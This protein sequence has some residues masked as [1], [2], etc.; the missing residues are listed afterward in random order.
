MAEALL[1]IMARPD[2]AAH[3]HERTFA[4]NVLLDLITR[5]EDAAA[6]RKVARRLRMMERPSLPL[7]RAILA[8]AERSERERILLDARLPASLLVEL[9][10]SEGAQGL[11][12]LARRR[13][14]PPLVSEMLLAWQEPELALELLRN[15][16]IRLEEE[17]YRLLARM[18]PRASALHGPII[19]REDLPPHAAFALFWHVGALQRRFIISRFVGDSGLLRRLLAMARPPRAPMPAEERA[20]QLETTLALMAEGALEEA[21]HN[22]A[23]L[24]GLARATCARIAADGGGEP[25]V[26]TL[27][28]LGL[29]RCRVPEAIMQLKAS[30][31][32]PLARGCSL[33]ELQALFDSLSGEKA[34]VPLLYWHWEETA[35]KAAQ[36]SQ[37]DLPESPQASVPEAPLAAQGERPAPAAMAPQQDQEAAQ[38]PSGVAEDRGPAPSEDMTPPEMTSA[39]EGPQAEQDSPPGSEPSLQP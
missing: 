39:R 22:L 18:A 37:E 11:R 28:A 12:L 21:A 9:A 19:S 14:L 3:P 29:A 1:D 31:A 36:E 27:K 24:T 6:V 7:L 30:P 34:W 20:F 38:A 8:R 2:N 32:S 16:D 17:A 13:N 35:Q 23:G 25:L 26:I 33:E 15:R 10:A 4:A 5:S